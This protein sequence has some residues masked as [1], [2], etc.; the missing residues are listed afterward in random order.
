MGK[1]QSVGSG[2]GGPTTKEVQMSAAGPGSGSPPP[3]A[4]A[5]SWTWDPNVPSGNA[6]ILDALPAGRFTFHPVSGGAAE[7][8]A[9]R[10]AGV[11]IWS[12]TISPGVADSA[13]FAL[14]DGRLY[15]LLYRAHVTGATLWSLD[16]TT[17]TR[18]FEVPLQ[19]VGLLRHSKYANRAQLR[20]I[21]DS[22]VAFGDETG[23]RY[24]EARD[25]TDGHLISHHM[26][27]P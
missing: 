13:S 25:A 5:I 17:G 9:E 8:R 27:Q 2:S 7:I 12:A 1:V 10:P 23:G 24:V 26:E 18:L 14:R 15:A 16:A 11:Q 20:L 19:G 4:K 6:A 21:G 22:P 3:G